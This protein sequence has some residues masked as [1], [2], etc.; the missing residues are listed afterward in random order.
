MRIKNSRESVKRSLPLFSM[1]SEIKGLFMRSNLAGSDSLP[2]DFYYLWIY[3]WL[4]L[5][6]LY[7]IGLVDLLSKYKESQQT[8]KHPSEV[9]WI[10]KKTLRDAGP[11]YYAHSG[12]SLGIGDQ[13]ILRLLYRIFRL[14]FDG[15]ELS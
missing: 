8:I 2:M 12:R 4:L 3:L 9:N 7:P 14:N 13:R 15:M 10:R 6:K 11:L 1:R 5:K